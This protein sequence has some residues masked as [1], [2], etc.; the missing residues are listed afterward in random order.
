M[1]KQKEQDEKTQYSIFILDFDQICFIE[2][3]E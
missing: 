3:M 2:K 1:L